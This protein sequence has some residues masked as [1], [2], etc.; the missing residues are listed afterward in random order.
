MYDNNVPQHLCKEKFF[1]K[2]KDIALQKSDKGESVV[3]VDKADHLNKMESL[4]NGV[5]KFKKINLKNDVFLNF[6]G[7]QEKRVDN[8]FKK[9]VASNSI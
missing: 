3:L 7:N 5:N 2:N 8:N 9:L 6:A 4:P 1:C